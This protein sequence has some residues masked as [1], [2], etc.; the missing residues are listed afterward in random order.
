MSL[1]CPS[2]P[3][4]VPAVRQ[5]PLIGPSS[6]Q[7]R[8]DPCDFLRSIGRNPTQIPN[9]VRRGLTGRENVKRLSERLC[10]GKEMDPPFVTIKTGPCMHGRM[11]G[12]HRM[13]ASCRVGIAEVPLEVLFRKEKD[14]PYIIL[15][16]A[17]AKQLFASCLR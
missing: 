15:P 9:T 14:S 11:D 10:A 13:I 8:V 17:R 7:T 5:T 6:L 4:V 1:E 16:K 3:W 12:R 2:Q